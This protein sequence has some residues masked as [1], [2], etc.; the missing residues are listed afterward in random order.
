MRDFTKPGLSKIERLAKLRGAG[1]ELFKVSPD[2]F[3]DA[4]WKLIDSQVKLTTI[5]VVSDEPFVPWE[6]MIP[7]RGSEPGLA[8]EIRDPLGVEFQ[9]GR[10]TRRSH[11]SGTQKISLNNSYVVAPGLRV[12]EVC[13]MPKKKLIL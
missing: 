4:F 2:H 13:L 12:L 7:C 6:L 9:V 8:P 3:K 5:A 10:M 11:V 1:K